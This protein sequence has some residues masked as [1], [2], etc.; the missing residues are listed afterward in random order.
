MK[1]SQYKKKTE[2]KNRKESLKQKEQG[3]EQRFICREKHREN[4]SPNAAM[5]IMTP[6]A[7][8]TLNKTL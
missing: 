1:K 7:P 3:E 5:T 6:I 8:H 4:K 2:R